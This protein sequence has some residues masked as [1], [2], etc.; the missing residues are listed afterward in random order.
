[1][2]RFRPPARRT[3][4]QRAL[5]RRLPRALRIALGPALAVLVVVFMATPVL[6]GGWAVTS[7]DPLP[8]GLQAGQTYR[9][10][11]VI[12]QHGV[13]LFDKATP[14]I[15]IQQGD[16]QLT[17]RGFPSGDPG[18]YVSEVQFPSAGS[19]TWVVDQS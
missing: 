11:Y 12:R 17:F 6:A 16:Q 8:A 2:S 14:Q 9:L 7:L 13:T 15:R 5:L 10:G 1:M 18:H 19:W 4:R 3:D